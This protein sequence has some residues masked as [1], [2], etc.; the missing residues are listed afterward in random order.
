MH[1][2]CTAGRDWVVDVRNYYTRWTRRNSRLQ[3]DILSVPYAL[4]VDPGQG[5]VKF[6]GHELMMF[7]PDEARLLGVRLIEGAALADGDRAIRDAPPDGPDP[8]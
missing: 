1:G 4:T 7:T 6:V 8:S 5:L 3:A 2:R